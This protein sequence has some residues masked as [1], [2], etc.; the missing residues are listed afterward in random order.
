MF[1]V[2]CPEEYKERQV[3]FCGAHGMGPLLRRLV[4]DLVCMY[5]H[6]FDGSVDMAT[7]SP[8]PP[9]PTPT[10]IHPTH[11]TIPG[12]TFVET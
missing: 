10:P 5:V 8:P 11:P 2:V 4:G 7:P 12:F 3:L 1:E 6:I 9:P